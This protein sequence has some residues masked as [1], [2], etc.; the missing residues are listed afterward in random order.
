MTKIGMSAGAIPEKLFV[1][2]VRSGH[3]GIGE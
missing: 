3:G 1:P 2:R